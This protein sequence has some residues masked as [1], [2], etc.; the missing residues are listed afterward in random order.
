MPGKFPP[1]APVGPWRGIILAGERGLEVQHTQVRP[2]IDGFDGWVTVDIGVSGELERAC[3][4]VGNHSVQLNIE[5]TPYGHRCTGR[6]RIPGVALWWPHTHGTPQRY[7]ASVTL[8]SGR[9][10][11]VLTLA[12]VA[13]R[14]VTISNSGGQGFAIQINDTSVFCRGTCWVPG[15]VADADPCSV[16]LR[17]QLEVVRRAGMNM[18]RLGGTMVYETNE[19]YELCDEMGILVW[20]DFMFANMDYP[21][22]QQEFLDSVTKE[23]EFHLNRF[24]HRPCITVLCGNSEIRQQT[25]MLGLA[26]ELQHS[27]WFDR[28]L[29]DLCEHYR[30]DV[31]YCPSSPSGGALP[32]YTDEGVSHYFGVGGYRRS[33]DDAYIAEPWFA[34]ECL[35]LSG[36]PEPESLAR[37]FGKQSSPA[38]MP[39]YVQRIPQDPG[40]D[41]SFAD[42]TDFYLQ[43]LFGCDPVRLREED[44]P[45]Y[46]HACRVAAGEVMA[47]VQTT[48]R[49]RDARC[50]GALIWLH[51][52]LWIG[53]G[54]GVVAA[55]GV[56]KSSYYYLKRVWSPLALLI[57]DVGVNGLRLVLIND[58]P[59]PFAGEITLRCAR[60]DAVSVATGSIRVD[61]AARQKLELSVDSILGA[62]IDSIA[63]VRG[64]RVA[65]IVAADFR[66][67][68]VA[69]DGA[70]V[71]AGAGDFSS[72]IS[73][74]RQLLSPFSRSVTVDHASGAAWGGG[75]CWRDR[76]AQRSEAASDPAMTGLS[77]L[78]ASKV[79]KFRDCHRS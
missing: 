52:D 10:E 76:C 4:S 40:A 47:A 21:V 44:E 48:W 33:L 55:D 5:A 46:L 37:A 30:P 11:T 49:R 56:P 28:V 74:G 34:T 61:C 53:S 42:V 57:R 77:P 73:S 79:T 63:S 22:Q 31:P 3:L 68:G 51:R 14:T 23:V 66:T 35:A 25:A 50:G 13:F 45:R 38:A 71:R 54:W 2:S 15:G 64:S 9:D 59:W 12:P 1:L 62:F 32:F 17:D 67:V 16:S 39:R 72:G 8:Q 60:Y 19:F 36:V 70:T 7:E 26:P 58:T 27:D 43:Q 24:G 29:P 6:I 78:I 20:Q 75:S 65:D 69:L 18:L 41:W